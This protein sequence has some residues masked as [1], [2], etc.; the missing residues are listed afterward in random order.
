ML[1]A[2]A[3]HRILPARGFQDETR[4]RSVTPDHGFWSQVSWRG[5]RLA[6]CFRCSRTTCNLTV[7]TSVACSFPAIGTSEPTSPPRPRHCRTT[8]CRWDG[9]RYP[10]LSSCYVEF[11]GHHALPTK[12]RYRCIPCCRP[13]SRRTFGRRRVFTTSATACQFSSF[14]QEHCFLERQGRHCR[15]RSKEAKGQRSKRGRK[16][17]GCR[18]ARVVHPVH[19][20]LEKPK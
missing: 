18:P 11:L 1:H 6:R 19:D 8:R 14:I 5:G 7:Q 13:F 20:T 9:L 4:G 3:F 16:E 2:T 10:L 12:I 15:L 17:A